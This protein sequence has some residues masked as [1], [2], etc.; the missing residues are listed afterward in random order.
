MGNKPTFEQWQQI[1]EDIKS[2]QGNVI[3][4]PFEY[5]EYFF[6]HFLEC[7]PPIIFGTNYTLCSEPYS[8]N[9]DGFTTYIGIFKN[10]DKWYGVITSVNEFKKLI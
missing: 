7:M 2:E 6:Y 1:M 5:G 10:V 4:I 9:K 3:E 8:H